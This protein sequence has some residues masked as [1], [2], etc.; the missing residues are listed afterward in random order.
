MVT[1]RKLK[2]EMKNSGC[3]MVFGHA[4]VCHSALREN[5][6]LRLNNDRKSPSV[7]HNSYTSLK[8]P[9]NNA[10]ESGNPV[11]AAPFWMAFCRQWEEGTKRRWWW[12]TGLGAESRVHL[13]EQPR[14]PA[15]KWAWLTASEVSAVLTASTQTFGS[16]CP[17]PCCIY[18]QEE[19]DLLFPPSLSSSPALGI[20][21]GPL[22]WK[23]ICSPKGNI[24]FGIINL[25]G[26]R[27]CTSCCNLFF[28]G[29]KVLFIYLK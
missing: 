20:P 17:L 6:S 29:R 18:R 4:F 7:T 1:R 10:G 24:F 14:Q 9:W 2:S 16:V 23:Q 11:P 25:A 15:Q 13:A 26:R 12:G 21:W 27:I 19:E 28:W 5:K 8:Q 3:S 22:Q